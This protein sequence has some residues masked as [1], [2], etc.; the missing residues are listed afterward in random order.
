MEAGRFGDCEFMGRAEE[1]CL[2][3]V[4]NPLFRAYDQLTIDDSRPS[5]GS[6]VSLRTYSLQGG[7]NLADSF[8]CRSLPG[9]KLG[10]YET[11]RVSGRVAWARSTGTQHAAGPPVAIKTSNTE[12]SKRFAREACAV[13]ALNHPNIDRDDWAYYRQLRNPR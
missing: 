1:R 7:I 11:S 6:S 5:H 9:D 8:R 3:L 12:F 4:G 2:P 13:A 10:P